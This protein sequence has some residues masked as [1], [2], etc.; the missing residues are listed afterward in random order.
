MR[1]IKWE[2]SS[3]KLGKKVRNKVPNPFHCDGIRKKCCMK[4]VIRQLKV[5]EL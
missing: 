4:K 5:Q 3:Q 1:R 2:L